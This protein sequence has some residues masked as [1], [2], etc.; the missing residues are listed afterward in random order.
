MKKTVK[1]IA[2]AMSKA[3]KKNATAFLID[4]KYIDNNIDFSEVKK[5]IKLSFDIDLNIEYHNDF[6]AFVFWHDP[7][8]I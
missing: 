8:T 3:M 5:I 2:K 7:E 4:E 1:R 6:K